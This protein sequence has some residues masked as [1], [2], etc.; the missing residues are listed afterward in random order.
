MTKKSLT[1]GKKGE[2]YA[3]KILEASG[4]KILEK[5]HKTPLGEIDIIAYDKKTLVFIEVKMRR[6]LNK[7]HPLEAVTEKK[8][9]QIIKNSMFFLN[10]MNWH[11]KDIRF[12]VISIITP[13]ISKGKT[14]VE[15]I[16]NAFGEER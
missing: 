6:S 5:N 4:Y 13:G 10:E 9:K 14:E 7:G 8:Q 16:K 1:L 2:E 3:A 15:I 11:D 12:D